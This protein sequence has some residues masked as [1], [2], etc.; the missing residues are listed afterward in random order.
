MSFMTVTLSH[1]EQSSLAHGIDAISGAWV[2]AR[3]GSPYRRM[4]QAFGLVGVL[5]FFEVTLGGFGWHPHLHSI[6][7]CEDQLGSDCCAERLARRYEHSLFKKGWRVNTRTSHAQRVTAVD[8]LAGY[9]AKDWHETKNSPLQL[10]R[11]GMAGCPAA[12]DFYFEAV[13]AMNRKRHAVLSPSL[14]RALFD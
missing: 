3:R 5:N 10:A 8:G 11:L 14:N 7:I 4:K 12:A 2:V 13:E 9:V 6:V 1:S